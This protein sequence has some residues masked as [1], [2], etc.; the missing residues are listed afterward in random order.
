MATGPHSW[1]ESLLPAV[2]QRSI[3][4]RRKYTSPGI[5][6]L[7]N[8]TQVGQV[9]LSPRILPAFLFYGKNIAA[10]MLKAGWGVT[11]EQVNF[12][13]IFTPRPFQL[14]TNLQ[15]GAEYGKLGK[16]GYLR[17]EADAK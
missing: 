3:W 10:E 2:A 8:P 13:L 4:S 17:L 14:L 5:R 7:A 16:E 12:V 15:A 1:E 9:Y 6:S 11:Y